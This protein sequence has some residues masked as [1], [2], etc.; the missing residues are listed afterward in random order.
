[1]LKLPAFFIF[2]YFLTFTLTFVVQVFFCPSI[3]TSEVIVTVPDFLPYT[4][5]FADTVAIEVLLDVNVTL[6]FCAATGTATARVDLLPSVTA[7]L[8]GTPTCSNK[9]AV[10]TLGAWVGR[11]T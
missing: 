5:P 10:T 9:E 6:E 8:A 11:S 1:M 2:P 4:V 7:L 3:T